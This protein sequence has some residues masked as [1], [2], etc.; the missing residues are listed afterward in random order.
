MDNLFVF[1]MGKKFILKQIGLP[2]IIFSRCQEWDMG[3]EKYGTHDNS[4]QVARNE[5]PKSCKN[6]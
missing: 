4:S 3:L 6:I 5:H 1:I 2:F